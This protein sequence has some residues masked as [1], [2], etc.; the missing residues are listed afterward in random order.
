M[1]KETYRKQLK[2]AELDLSELLKQRE[3]VERKIASIKLAIAGLAAVCGDKT[4]TADIES[5]V[6]ESEGLTELCRS[7]LK[8]ADGP[9]TAMEV[10]QVLKEKGYD[11][12]RFSSPLAAIH[13]ILKRLWEMGEV[14]RTKKNQK[15]A[16][17][18][19]LF[20]ARRSS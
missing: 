17:I 15:S 1:K 2:A 7:V 14:D 16:Y 3:R 13:T 12:S 20:S 5:F 10:R 18:W 9:L 19:K 8:T 11:F 6:K 4:S